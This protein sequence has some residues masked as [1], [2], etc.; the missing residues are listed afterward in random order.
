MFKFSLT[1]NACCYIP[2]KS[3][4]IFTN[5]KNLEAHIRFVAKNGLVKRK[6]ILC[7][8]RVAK[9]VNYVEEEWQNT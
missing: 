2:G 4:L 3:I 9:H 6:R 1:W 7:G 5:V 8:G